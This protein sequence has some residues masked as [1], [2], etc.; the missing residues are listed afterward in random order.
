MRNAH[1][2]S[3]KRSGNLEVGKQVRKE[4]G[5]RGRKGIAT[6]SAAGG[7]LAHFIQG[8][9]QVRYRPVSEM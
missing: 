1:T 4:T 5:L 2:L 9:L 7:G 8:S 3:V 6:G